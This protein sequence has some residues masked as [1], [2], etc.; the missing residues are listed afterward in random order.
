[1]TSLFNSCDCLPRSPIGQCQPSTQTGI[2]AP[3]LQ[4]Y[5]ESFLSL[6]YFLFLSSFLVFEV[7]LGLSG[8]L[9]MNSVVVN[10]PIF[11]GYSFGVIWIFLLLYLPSLGIFQYHNELLCFLLLLIWLRKKIDWMGKEIFRNGSKPT[12]F[13]GVKTEA[14]CVGTSQV[15][16]ALT[17]V[18]VGWWQRACW[19]AV[20]SSYLGIEFLSF[21]EVSF[22]FNYAFSWNLLNHPS[23]DMNV[24][25]SGVDK[26]LLY[27]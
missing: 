1:M 26:D 5:A 21:W 10:L 8:R 14:L 16:G 11:P 6:I 15:W 17:S 19:V 9:L 7:A 27:Q 13:S 23:D 24:A 22:P 20:W 2:P 12:G 3:A 18:R 4:S 25:P